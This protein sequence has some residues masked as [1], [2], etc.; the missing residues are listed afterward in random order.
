MIT[1]ALTRSYNYYNKYF[2]YT[3]RLTQNHKLTKIEYT[4]DGEKVSNV[5]AR[6][7]TVQKLVK[8]LA[9]RIRWHRSG[10]S[11][12]RAQDHAE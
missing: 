2:I 11:I 5:A 4:D 8:Q 6:S 12:S 7:I 9:K 1:I 10:S 3:A